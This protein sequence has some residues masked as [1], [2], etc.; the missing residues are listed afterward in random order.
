MKNKSIKEQYQD[1]AQEVLERRPKDETLSDKI[2]DTG[3]GK[4]ASSDNVLQIEDVKDFISKLKDEFDE[5][6]G[7]REQWIDDIIDKLAG[8]AL[9]HSPPSD[10]KKSV[11][12]ADE[13]TPG[14]S[15]SLLDEESSGTHD[16]QEIVLGN[17][18]R[19]LEATQTKKPLKRPAGS[20][21]ASCTNPKGCGYYYVT[22]EGLEQD[23]EEGQLCPTC[24]IHN[25]GIG[26]GERAKG[27]DSP[28]LPKTG[29]AY[30]KGCGEYDSKNPELTRCCG[31]ILF[32]NEIWLCPK[33]KGS[34]NQGCNNNVIQKEYYNEINK[35][36][37]FEECLDAVTD[38]QGSCSKCKDM[39]CGEPCDK[40]G[41]ETVCDRCLKE[42]S[43]DY[44]KVNETLHEE[45]KRLNNRI[46]KYAKEKSKTTDNKGYT[47]K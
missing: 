21:N 37:S 2:Y 20:G 25:P 19:T 15:S 18:E 42:S 1:K 7:G 33:C 13:D 39:P 8:D 3:L 6:E 38:N 12:S 44:K 14:V 17:A 47:N 45:I 11:E 4:Y 22:E 43:I 31:D 28:P 40:C 46:G 29:S 35:N 32:N 36:A 26:K 9:I 30:P 27:F 16:Q 24:N 5:I 34:D 23:C 10:L 41:K